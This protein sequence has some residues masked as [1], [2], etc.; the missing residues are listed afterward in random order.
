MAFTPFKNTAQ[1]IKNY[2][3]YFDSQNFITLSDSAPLPSSALIATIDFNLK[4]TMYDVSEAALCESLIF[5]VLQDV[6]KHFKENLFLWSHT[7]IEADENL[8]GITDYL[9]AKKSEYGRI[10]GMPLLT[11]VEAKKDNLEYRLGFR[12]LQ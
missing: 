11:T 7:S 3:L 5:P 8:I 12:L 4:E 6:W 9:I 2:H 1:V 10:L